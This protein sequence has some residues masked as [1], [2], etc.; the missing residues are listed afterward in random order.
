M[1]GTFEYFISRETKVNG[2]DKLLR[3]KRFS[4]FKTFFTAGHVSLYGVSILFVLLFFIFVVF[5]PQFFK[6]RTGIYKL[7]CKEIRHK[8][9]VAVSQY[10]ISNTRKIAKEGQ[11][12]DLDLLKTEGFLMEIQKCPEN[13]KFVFGPEGDVLCSLH[14]PKPEPKKEDKSSAK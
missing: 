12:I 6:M 3:T 4:F 11:P 7:A 13:G 2:S 5:T 10:G 9:E 8:I 14:H 1:C